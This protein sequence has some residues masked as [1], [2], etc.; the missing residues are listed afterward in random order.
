MPKVVNFVF[1]L[2]GVIQVFGPISLCFWTNLGNFWPIFKK[3]NYL[4]LLSFYIYLLW[5]LLTFLYYFSIGA[6]ANYRKFS[7][8]DP[9]TRIILQFCGSNIQCRFHQAKIKL[10]A[11]L[12]SFMEA[13]GRS[14]QIVGTVQFL[15]FVKLRSLFLCSLSAE[16][17]SQ[18][19]RFPACLS[20]WAP[21]SV[22]K[23]INIWWHVSHTSDL[24]CLLPFSQIYDPLPPLKTHVITWGPHR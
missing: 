22:F 11:R 2:L 23:F 4:P 15:V 10:S 18:L 14:M 9:H 3:S 16:G 6:I 19:Y 12:S 24:S 20:V 8:L 7:S 21:F 13:L 17:R 5:S 1:I